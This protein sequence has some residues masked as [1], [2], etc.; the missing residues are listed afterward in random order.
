MGWNETVQELVMERHATHLPTF[1]YTIA[2]KF[3]DDKCYQPWPIHFGSVEEAE[4]WININ[5]PESIR[6]GMEWVILE[7]Q[8]IERWN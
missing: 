5:H 8:T 4:S 1:Y 3:D 7:H 2:H 6:T